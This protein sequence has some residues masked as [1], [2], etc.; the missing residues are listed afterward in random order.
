MK[1]KLTRMRARIVPESEAD[2]M[3]LRKEQASTRGAKKVPGTGLSSNNGGKH[4]PP[5]NASATKGEVFEVAF[6]AGPC[7]GR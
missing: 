1:I 5:R 6:R 2:V 4:R 3:K 7:A